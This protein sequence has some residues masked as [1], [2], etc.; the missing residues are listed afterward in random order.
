MIP[1]KKYISHFKK[2]ISI[3]YINVNRDYLGGKGL[4]K[5]IYTF[6]LI[7]IF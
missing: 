2:T 4:Y 6:R 3:L 1:F 7:C 5:I